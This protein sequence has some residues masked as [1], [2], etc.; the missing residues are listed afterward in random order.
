[1]S[2]GVPLSERVTPQ[3]TPLLLHTCE[4]VPARGEDRV[5]RADD[6]GISVITV[7]F[8]VWQSKLDLIA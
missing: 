3:C 2:D 6:P 1:M 8:A 7:V 5:P 4:L